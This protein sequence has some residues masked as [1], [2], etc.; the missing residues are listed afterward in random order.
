MAGH[1][2]DPT[3]PAS[4]RRT[5]AR[6][7][8]Y[9]TTHQHVENPWS[10]SRCVLLESYCHSFRALPYCAHIGRHGL[11]RWQDREA[12]AGSCGFIAIGVR[13]AG[14]E[15]SCIAHL[16]LGRRN[17]MIL[18]LSRIAKPRD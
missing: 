12:A 7:L 2:H 14:M 1:R 17:P 11:D 15:L 18:T 10:L 8:G 6:V 3:A 9:E 16:E 13:A 5:G 4:W